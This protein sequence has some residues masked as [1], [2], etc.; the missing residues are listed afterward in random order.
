M[1][2]REMTTGTAPTT[3]VRLQC[4]TPDLKQLEKYYGASTVV[5]RRSSPPQCACVIPS[6]TRCM[7][8]HGHAQMSTTCDGVSFKVNLRW[9]VSRSGRSVR[10]ASTPSSGRA[11]SLFD[12]CRSSAPHVQ[13]FR[14]S[15]PL[16]IV[17]PR[18]WADIMPA[19]CVINGLQTV[20]TPP[21]LD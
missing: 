12:P 16:P 14:P 15:T 19:R 5:N 1:H 11:V 8:R 13:V 10:F 3:K 4:T 18:V 21:E 20:L 17:S 2:D 7:H 9:T 6:G